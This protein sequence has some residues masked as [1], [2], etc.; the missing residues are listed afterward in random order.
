MEALL[1]RCGKSIV[2]SGRY[3]RHNVSG[4]ERSS[5][6]LIDE[7]GRLFG[8][9]NVYDAAVV[10]IVGLAVVGG[11]VVLLDHFA[12]EDD[13]GGE[14]VTRYVTLDLGE[15]SP[16]VAA[17]ISAGD[18]DG[19]LTVTDTY[20]GP[21]A[22]GNVSVLARVRVEGTMDGERFE[23]FGNR[24]GPGAPLDLETD[25]YTVDGEV[26]ALATNNE[27]IATETTPVVVETELASATA[28]FVQR[29]DTSRIDG[30]TVGTVTEATVE[31]ATDSGS[32]TALVGLSLV[33]VSYDSRTYFGSRELLVGNAVPFRTDR[34]A[35]SGVVTQVDTASLSESGRNRTVTVELENVDPDVADGY[36]VGLVER[37]GGETVARVTGV[38]TEP[39]AVVVTSESGEVYERDHPRNLDVTL[40]TSLR[41]RDTA[42]GLRFR[43][44][45]LREGGTVR[46]DFGTIATNGTVTNIG[47]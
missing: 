5:V 22:G 42:D 10:V 1:C 47:T 6:S 7:R 4:L 20:L 17:Q 33:T 43:T 30:R 3:E 24:V 35:F 36:E 19:G 18:T 8:R 38:T 13:S 12:A 34:Y 29:N 11:A 31:P 2:V 9:V 25:S 32:R 14:S 28:A 15:R 27:S 16:T 45:P 44:R 37:S 46:F 26:V 40:T 41:V 23:Y 21:A 39:A